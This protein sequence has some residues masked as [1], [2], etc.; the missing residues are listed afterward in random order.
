[1][2]TI[3]ALQDD[4][5]HME[6]ASAE[7]FGSSVIVAPHPDDETLGCGGTVALLRKA[8]IPVSH[9]NSK[10]YPTTKLTALRE[11]EAIKAVNLLGGNANCLDFMKLKDS[12]IPYANDPGF[13]HAVSRMTEILNR[14]RPTSVFVPWRNDPH[15]D[16]RATYQIVMESLKSCTITKPRVLEYL[17]W[18]WERG[19][20]DDIKDIINIKKWVV[21][22]EET[23]HIKNLALAAHASQVTRLID[24]DP[25][26]FILSPQVIGHFNITR[27]LF[28]ES[29][30]EN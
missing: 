29:P 2:S 5:Y 25:E 1:M 17:V 10:K 28:F 9:P 3:A 22:V 23:L 27:E 20:P 7:Q 24:D 14:T 30:I 6:T 8:R 12:M 13:E 21:D 16:H 26:G 4:I 11:Q 19:N 15:N 18:F